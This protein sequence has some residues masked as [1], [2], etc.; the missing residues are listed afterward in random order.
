LNFQRVPERRASRP[1]L[2][3]TLSRLLVN[4][5]NSETGDDR[6]G[7]PKK[8]GL[9]SAQDV[10]GDTAEDTRLLHEMA[11]KARD[12]ITSFKW[13]LPIRSIRLADGVGG[14]IAVFLA[15]FDGKIGGTDDR[16]WVFVGDL[17]S[18]YMIVEPPATAQDALDGYCEL[19]EDWVNA[20]LVTHNFENVFPVDAA[21]TA[22]NA[23]LLRTRIAFIR[24]EIIPSAPT[25]SVGVYR[26]G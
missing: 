24:K 17:P 26:G 22:A 4:N 1:I 3:G 20:V 15:E 8:A 5:M 21:Q 19:M 18:A 6:A 25:E 7:T 2:G 9:I 13:C 11:A 16:L 12:Y 23:E 10:L 14:I